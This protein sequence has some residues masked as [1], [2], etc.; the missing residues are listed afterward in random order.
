V[1][2]QLSEHG[3]LLIADEVITGFGRSGSWF[4]SAHN[5]MDPDV[6]ITAKGIT[7]GYI[8]LG[9]VLM[10]DE[11]GSVITG[12]DTHFFH[13]HTYYGHPVASAVALANLDLLAGENL[14]ERAN[15]VGARLGAGLAPAA[16]LPVVGDIRVAGAMIGIELVTDRRTRENLP[17]PAVI[18]A[19]DELQDDYGVLV[20]DYGSTIVMGPPLVLTDEEADR[21]ASALVDVLSRLG[22]DGTLHPRR[23]A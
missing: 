18:A 3:I 2:R 23:A 17:N 9:A 1:R 19:I 22:T 20:R 12:G 13:G 4:Q 10:R 21:A 15:A 8:P 6:V 16:E 7:S 5:G 14:V 11:I